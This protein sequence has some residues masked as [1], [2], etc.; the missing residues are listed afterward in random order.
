MLP[1][2]IPGRFS[3]S[4]AAAPPLLASSLPGACTL[5]PPLLPPLTPREA[6]GPCPQVPVEPRGGIWEV[7]RVLSAQGTQVPAP[8][9][10][11]LVF[12]LREGLVPLSRAWG[13]WE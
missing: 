13:L 7:T 1:F 3:C 6:P 2:I 8:L 10:A 5:L 9:P 12:S 11:G 4:T